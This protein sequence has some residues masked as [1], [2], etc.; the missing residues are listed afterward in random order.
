MNKTT[1]A[2]RDF[3]AEFKAARIE[4]RRPGVSNAD[5]AKWERKSDT[6]LR[7][8]ERAGVFFDWVDVDEQARVELY[9]TGRSW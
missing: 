3:T 8:A 9:G 5:R 4:S 1:A 7:A 6:I 2:P